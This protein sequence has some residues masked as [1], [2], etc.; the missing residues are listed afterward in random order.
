MSYLT[1]PYRYVPKVCTPDQIVGATNSSTTSGGWSTNINTVWAAISSA[2]VAENSKIEKIGVCYATTYKQP[3]ATKFCAYTNNSGVP[4]AFICMTES[5]IIDG[6]IGWSDLD[7]VDSS[8][9]VDPHVITASE[10]GYIWIGWWGDD[11]AEECFDTGS[12]SWQ[13]S[14]QTF[15]A[16]N[17][18]EPDDP[19]STDILKGAQITG[20]LTCCVI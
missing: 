6:F 20:R 4:D 11:G 19:F 13:M 15:D 7:V 9:S 10:A 8:G 5:T 12:T 1:N 14:T 18:A 3:T 16:S 17:T 2:T